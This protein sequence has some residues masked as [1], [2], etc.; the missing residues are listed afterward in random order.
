MNLGSA[1]DDGLSL[2]CL[3]ACILCQGYELSQ[4]EVLRMGAI[5]LAAL[6]ERVGTDAVLDDIVG[7]AQSRID[8]GQELA[9]AFGEL[10]LDAL[11][12]C[13][14]VHLAVDDAENLRALG[15]LA[16][17]HIF[18]QAGPVFRGGCRPDDARLELVE[19]L[20]VVGERCGAVLSQPGVV[21]VGTLRRGIAV[22]GDALDADILLATHLVDGGHDLLQLLGVATVGGVEVDLVETE[23]DVGTT[24]QLAFLL[25]VVRRELHTH[26]RHALWFLVAHETGHVGQ[27]GQVAASAEV[28]F[29]LQL[30]RPHPGLIGD[31]GMVELRLAVARPL[32][33]ARVAISLYALPALIE[34]MLCAAV[35]YQ[36]LEG[37]A[38]RPVFRYE[39]RT[40]GYRL[41]VVER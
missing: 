28:F 6:F 1:V 22:D 14:G 34:H 40:D 36:R 23:V 4:R 7:V 29:Q 9:I 33:V 19:L 41:F 10:L 17:V 11:V 15:N 25:V 5:D 31:G 3:H 2:G 16:L 13:I 35:H 37:N 21:L 30:V 18:A 24:F 12:L 26:Q 20:D 8:I 32:D 38:L 39:Y 27:V